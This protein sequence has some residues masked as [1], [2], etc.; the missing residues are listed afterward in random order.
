MPKVSEDK[1]FVLFS[2]EEIDAYKA[3]QAQHEDGYL[4]ELIIK[5]ARAQG[6][7]VLAVWEALLGP[8]A[9]K[10]T[11]WAPVRIAE[12]V[13]VTQERMDDIVETTLNAV[14]PEFEAYKRRTER[15]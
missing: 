12:H 5:Y 8:L 2:Q 9:D 11:K 10:N 3:I 13:G 6:G 7:D 1:S 14:R 4:D 15:S